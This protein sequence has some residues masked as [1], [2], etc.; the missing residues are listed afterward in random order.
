MEAN[1]VPLHSWDNRR[2]R[3]Q[4]LSALLTPDRVVATE[5]F[6]SPPFPISKL[7]IQGGFPMLQCLF[8]SLLLD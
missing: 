6:S 3:P 8:D 7:E 5:L 2:G 4:V 1:D